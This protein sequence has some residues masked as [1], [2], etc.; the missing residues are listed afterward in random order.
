[1]KILNFTLLILNY[2]TE[3]KQFHLEYNLECRM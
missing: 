3:N 2:P 1:M